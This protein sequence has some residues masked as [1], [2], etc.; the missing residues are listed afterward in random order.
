[1]RTFLVAAALTLAACTP[2]ETP[3]APLVAVAVDAP[4]GEYKLDKAHAS[5]VARVVHLGLSH[6]TLRLTG[7][8]ATLSFNAEDP[9]QSSVSAS[10]AANTVSTEFPGTVDFNAELENSEWLDAATYPLITFN[11]TG[12]E[13]TGPNTGRMSGSL[14]MRGVTKPVVLDVTFNHA[15]QQHPFGLPGALLGFSAHGTIKRSEFGLTKFIPPSEGAPGIADEV[16]IAIE[17]E[18]TRLPAPTNPVN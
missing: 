16:E 2:A 1:M 8:D 5:L 10:I 4:S 13:L 11:S 18:F 9:T 7:L 3:P 12:V 17:A 15:Y 14:T 6:Y